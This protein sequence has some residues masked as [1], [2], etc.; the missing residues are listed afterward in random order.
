MAE[1][2]VLGIVPARAGS[3]GIAKKNIRKVADKPLIAYSI[4]AALQSKAIQRLIVS[5][6]SPEI[7]KCARNY[8]A[9]IPFLRPAEISQDDTHGVEP[10][11]HAL[12]WLNAREGYHPDFVMLLQPTSPL[13]TVSDIRSAIQLV[14]DKSADGVVSVTFAKQHPW[15]TKVLNEDGTLT[16]FIKSDL[17]STRRQDLTPLYVLNG[18]IYLAR[19]EVILTHQTFFTS[20]TYAYV[21][22]A[23]RSIDID[24]SWDLYLADLILR[25]RARK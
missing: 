25:E 24:T 2:N 8:G 7:A 17:S 4:E 22:P 11:L 16:D 10:V 18:A 9:E 21:M 5:T 3:K 23:E 19:T 14:V 13:R 20:R 12:E 1:L 6:D 15:W